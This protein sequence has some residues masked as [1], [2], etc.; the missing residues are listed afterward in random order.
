MDAALE[1]SSASADGRG[2]LLDVRFAAANTLA[3]GKG[4]RRPMPLVVMFVSV[5]ILVEASMIVPLPYVPVVVVLWG[6]VL[7]IVELRVL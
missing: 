1:V 6:T 5:V 3:G 2:V 7:V 4:I